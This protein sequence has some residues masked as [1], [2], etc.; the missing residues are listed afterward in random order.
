MDGYL[1]KPIRPELLMNETKRVTGD[2][3]H[4]PVPQM[5]A[6][7]AE[8]PRHTD[9]DLNDLME[10]LGGD[11]EFLRELLVIFRQDVQMNLEKS[12]AAMEKRDLE[13]L[14]R[15]AHT[16]KGMLKNLSM[17]TA[18]ES[19]AALEQAARE[20]LTEKSEELLLRLSNELEAILPEVESQLAEVKP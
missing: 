19:A 13:G 15:A 10:R 9:W 16:I 4:D 3:G 5:P 6:A 18:A 20:N 1:S 2:G 14:S 8:K 12:R 11:Q 7:V 17:G